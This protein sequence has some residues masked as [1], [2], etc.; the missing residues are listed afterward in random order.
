MHVNKG[1]ERKK[2]PGDKNGL[3]KRRATGKGRDPRPRKTYSMQEYYHQHPTLGRSAFQIISV[4]I[5]CFGLCVRVPLSPA[6]PSLL[7]QIKI[8]FLLY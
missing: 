1:Q 8:K 3:T 7:V 4:L 2:A 5:N 6:V